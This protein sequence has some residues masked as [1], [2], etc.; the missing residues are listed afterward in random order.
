MS[1]DN[2]LDS[3]Q[4]QHEAAW[5]EKQRKEDYICYLA[6]VVREG[7][8]ICRDTPFKQVCHKHFKEYVET[9]FTPSKDMLA[10]ISDSFLDDEGSRDVAYL[11]ASFQQIIELSVEFIESIEVAGEYCDANEWREMES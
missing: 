6:T 2:F 8:C 3:K 4:E 11:E 9:W 5:Y 10:L 7:G 1:Y